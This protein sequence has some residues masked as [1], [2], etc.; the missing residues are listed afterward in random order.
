MIDRIDLGRRFQER[1]LAALS[2]CLPVL[3]FRRPWFN[4]E[5]DRTITAV[6]FV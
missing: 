5:D 2:D 6:E 4:L 1:S 3:H